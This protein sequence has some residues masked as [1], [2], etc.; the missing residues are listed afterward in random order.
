MI[1]RN[2]PIPCSTKQRFVT[3]ELNQQRVRIR[4]LEGDAPDPDAC[5]EI[6]QCVITELPPGLPAG[7]PIEVTYSFD[8]NGRIQV[9]ACDVT[10]G[11]EARTEIIRAA[12]LGQKDVGALT[13]VVADLAV[14]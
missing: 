11:R 6:G 13:G 3:R 1:Q 9:H 7:S 8:Q 5:Y 2:T 14:E 12:G 10:G 4:I